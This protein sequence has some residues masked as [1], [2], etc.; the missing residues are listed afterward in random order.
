MTEHRIP[1]EAYQQYLTMRIDSKPYLI[2]SPNDRY[3]PHHIRSCNGCIG[4]CCMLTRIDALTLDELKFLAAVTFSRDILG[5]IDLDTERDLDALYAYK[6][7]HLSLSHITNG[8]LAY[9]VLLVKNQRERSCSISPATACRHLTDEGRCGTYE[10]RSLTCP[11]FKPGCKICKDIYIRKGSPAGI[12]YGEALNVGE[13][14][15]VIIDPNYKP[16]V[17]NFT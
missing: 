6:R 10:H 11:E 15:F 5:Y 3:V 4:S 14:V 1:L 16:R 12:A 17:F 13:Q 2:Y 8:L 9:N 7:P